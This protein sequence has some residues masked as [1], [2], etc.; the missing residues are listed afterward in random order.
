MGSGRPGEC[1]AAALPRVEVALRDVTGSATA[2]SLVE[3]LARVPRRSTSSAMTGSVLV[4]TPEPS[5]FPLNEAEFWNF[6]FWEWLP[7]P[8][9]EI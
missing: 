3:R 6:G 2:P 7:C 1:G 9:S 8:L 4:C 5:R